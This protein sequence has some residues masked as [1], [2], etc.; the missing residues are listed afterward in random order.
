MPLKCRYGRTNIFPNLSAGC[1]LAS[2]VLSIGSGPGVVT[3]VIVGVVIHAVITGRE[4]GD[5]TVVTV[6]EVLLLLLPVVL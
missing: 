4:S 5:I 1:I 3:V 6:I 2:G